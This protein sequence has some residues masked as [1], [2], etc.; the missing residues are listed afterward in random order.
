MEHLFNSTQSDFWITKIIQSNQKHIKLFK[1]ITPE[2][3]QISK[4]GWSKTPTLSHLL[5][6]LSALSLLKEQARAI[7]QSE[8]QEASNHIFEVKLISYLS[9]WN[10]HHVFSNI[11]IFSF[12]WHVI[13]SNFL[14]A[15]CPFF[16][17]CATLWP[18]R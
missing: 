2:P 5:R 8:L 7:L 13:P 16:L 12:P 18:A 4:P 6:T 15:C 11:I 10:Y 9:K 3:S 17:L 1:P 14:R